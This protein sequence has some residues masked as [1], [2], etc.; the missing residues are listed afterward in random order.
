MKKFFLFI[1]ILIVLINMG[2]LY[3]RFDISTNKEEITF[4]KVVYENADYID[5]SLSASDNAELVEFL[6]ILMVQLDYA[7]SPVDMVPELDKNSTNPDDY[8]YK[9]E[10]KEYY[11]E[12]HTRKN[13]EIFDTIKISDYKSLYIS[14]LMPF[15]EYTYTLNAFELN[16]K[17]I[18][19]TLDK[20]EDVE[21][22]YV[23]YM[24]EKGY[25]EDYVIDIKDEMPKIKDNMLDGTRMADGDEDYYFRRYTGEGVTVGL[26]EL[27]IID[28]THEN[29]VGVDVTVHN[30]LLLNETPSE[31]ATMVASI[32]GGNEGIACDASFLTSQIMGG[33]SEEI[34]WLCNN[35]ADIIN[36]SFGTNTRTGIY[37]GMSA[38]VDYAT[39]VYNQIFVASAGNTDDTT[40]YYLGDPALAYNAITVGAMDTNYNWRNFSCY[41][42]A[43][44]P[45]KPTIM[46]KGYSIRITNYEY[47]FYDGTS[48]AAAFVTGLSAMIFERIPALIDQP[49]KYI[50]LMTSGATRTLDD[51]WYDMVNNFDEFMG[52]GEYNYQNI[53]D[54][55][56]NA[57]N[58][59]TSP[60]SGNT[61]IYR[62]ELTLDAGD[63]IQAAITWLSYAYKDNVSTAARSDYDI[64]IMYDGAVISAGSSTYNN[65][66]M[67]TFTAEYDNSDIMIMVI[68]Y[69]ATVLE[70]EQVSLAY[71][72]TT[73]E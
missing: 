56:A 61:I 47:D 73:A 38:Y 62:Q 28:T 16:K 70:D 35:G 65:V 45:I 69:G 17:T 64:R 6:V 53:I 31:H 4:D 49:M 5:S 36:M 14:T 26:L 19:S 67:A 50:A 55:Y 25:Y 32:I 58:I 59:T 13:K 52:A 30:Q 46:A 23:Q 15:I 72:I 39:R 41:E 9:P 21:K 8:L 33:I 22:I 68:Q 10:H 1:S 63:S 18:L 24:P 27:G 11:K 48:F 44:G 37:G 60:S 66:E 7:N 43:S 51:Y 20:H 34:D 42:T 2:I 54:N 71:N 12:Y 57:V 29:F 3:Y 40:N